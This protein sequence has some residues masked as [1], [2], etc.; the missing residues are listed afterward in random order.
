MKKILTFVIILFSVVVINAAA[1]SNDV[2]D[3]VYYWDAGSI[4]DTLGAAFDTVVSTDSVILYNKKRFEPGW[5]YILTRRP[6]TG[7]G[8]DSLYMKLIL[9]ALSED[10][11]LYYRTTIDSPMVAGGNSLL[12]PI[13]SS[14]YGEKFTIK[15]IGYTGN[16]GQ[17][18]LPYMR[19]QRRRPATMT[20]QKSF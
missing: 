17:L 10:G 6:I 3:A 16:G 1:P 14:C 8:T 12:L 15:V 7:T 19:L 20:N 11:T 5:E 13:G 4:S 9:D 2:V 18:I